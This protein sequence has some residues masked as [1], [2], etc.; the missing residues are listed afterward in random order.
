MALVKKLNVELTIADE[1]VDEY[2]DMG[3]SLLDGKGNVIKR[4]LTDAELVAELKKDNLAL[5]DEINSLKQEI[6]K[7]T[8]E[9]IAL[10]SSHNVSNEFSEDNNTLSTTKSKRANKGI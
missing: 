4:K 2:L 5:I 10:K 3:Y 8:T 9:N 7:L 6:A 1:L